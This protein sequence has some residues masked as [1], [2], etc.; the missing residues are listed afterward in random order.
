VKILVLVYGNLGARVSGPEI[1]GLAVARNLAR[2]HDVTV[3]IGDGEGDAGDGIRVVP[4]TRRS[5]A[6]EARR[7]DVFMAPQVPPYVLAM[8]ALR[9]LLTVSDQYDPVELEVAHMDGKQAQTG[10]RAARAARRLQ[11]RYADVVLCANDAQRAVLDE[12]LS[13]VGGGPAVAVVPFGLPPAPEPSDRRPLRELFPQIGETDK[14][15][16]W[17]GSVWRWLDAESA[18]RAVAGLDGVRLVI[19]AGKPRSQATGL[20]ATDSARDLARSLGV[21]GDKVLFVDSWIP[22]EERHH[23]LRDADLGLTLHGATAEAELAARSRYLDYLWAGLPCVLAR[24]DELADRF[25]SSGFA[26]LVPPLDP[27]AVR[28]ELARRLADAD[29]LSRARE[30]GVRLAETMSWDAALR[31]LEHTLAAAPPARALRARASLGLLGAVGAEYVRLGRDA[32][33]A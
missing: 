30:A 6:R 22:Y 11:L 24:G 29:G 10:V 13:A 5:L 16:L 20:Q 26:T 3:A 7:A 9:P 18:I 32:L 31:P 23:W 12:E 33:T 1:R 8:K 4:A 27:D 15:V 2:R 14:V 17:W 28:S 21:L 25:A 19:T